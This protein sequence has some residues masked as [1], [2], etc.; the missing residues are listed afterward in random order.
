M[1]AQAYAGNWMFLQL[2]VGYIIGRIIVS[3]LFIPAYFRG[4]LLTTYELLQPPLRSQRE[5]PERVDL[6]ADALAGRWHPPC[7]RRA[8]V[9]TVVTGAP[10]DWTI[11]ILGAAMIV[12]TMRGGVSAVIWT[13][14][15][16]LF[17]YVAGALL[18]VF[19]IAACAD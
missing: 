9:I 12:Y 5:E 7:T 1:P 13:D 4:E 3:A 16:Q 8:L 18:L 17:V 19:R 11:I 15:V 10:M 2:V 14:V 6:P